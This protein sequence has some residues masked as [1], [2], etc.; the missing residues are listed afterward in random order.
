MCIYTMY[1]YMGE[2][3]GNNSYITTNLQE[4]NFAAQYTNAYI[5]TFVM[6][7]LHDDEVF[8]PRAS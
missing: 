4:L 3:S 2:L 8:F 6:Q 1:A 5:R 7:M